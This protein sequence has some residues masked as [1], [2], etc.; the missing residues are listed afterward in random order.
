MKDNIEFIIIS[1][2]N[3]FNFLFV[4]CH[5]HKKKK[6]Y[7]YMSV[8]NKAHTK[9]TDALESIMTQVRAKIY[10]LNYFR[11]FDI[12]FSLL[13]ICLCQTANSISAGTQR[14]LLLI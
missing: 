13:G 11:L 7:I 1:D 8:F 6:E 4:L 10:L 3:L 12:D 14:N 5:F 2:A 9:A